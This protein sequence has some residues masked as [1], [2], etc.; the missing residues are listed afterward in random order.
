MSLL[1]DQGLD[2]KLRLDFI[3][4]GSDK[5]QE[6]F[7]RVSK[8]ASN[9]PPAA[10]RIE[11]A[12]EAAVEKVHA[13]KTSTSEKVENAKG[14]VREAKERTRGVVEELKTKTEK[15]VAKASERI[16][17]AAGSV[18]EKANDL[19]NRPAAFSEGVEE[20]VLR[21]ESALTGK[22][23][24][25]F[26]EATTSSQQP[27]PSPPG[28]LSKDNQPG[29]DENVYTRALPI[30]FEPPPGYKRPKPPAPPPSKTAES[31]K[32]D[33]LPLVAPAIAGIAASE[34]VI[35]ELAST[36]DSLA[37]FVK[38]NP[39]AA[40]SAKP[41]LDTAKTDLEELAKRIEQARTEERVKLE[42]QLDDQAREYT[43]KLLE[44]EM[45]S[46]DKLDEQ[47]LEFKHFY[48]DER[49]KLTQAYRDRL[50]NELRTQSEIIN[51]R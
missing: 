23:F 29:N 47:E 8:S 35:S 28:P 7:N 49:R 21:A 26:L 20:L 50:E 11:K 46:Q 38:D 30:G 24:G 27:V 37:N 32:E 40:S 39:S 4:T 42:A 2:D 14:K 19:I 12:K 16:R 5:M 15:N 6:V 10:E 31:K 18:E 43:L 44:L 41:I 33:V 36:I 34:P 51:E 13:I 45:A 9:G 48:E 3:K 1:E 17:E 22:S 25:N